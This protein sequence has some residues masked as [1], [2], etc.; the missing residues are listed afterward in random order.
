MSAQTES[1]PRPH[2]LTVQDYYRMAEVGLLSP[3]DRVELI[4]GEIIEMPPI[5]DRHADVVAAA[6]A[7][8]AIGCIVARDDDDAFP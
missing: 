4:E 6:F 3:D 5:G 7:G 1:W 8:L 2:L